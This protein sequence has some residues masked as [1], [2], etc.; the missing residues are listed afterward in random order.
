M[1]WCVDS[2]YKN[3]RLPDDLDTFMY[4][5]NYSTSHK[6]LLLPNKLRRLFIKDYDNK[7]L[8]PDSLEILA[9]G[10]EYQHFNI[11]C[12]SIEL[13]SNLFVLL[14]ILPIKLP[15]NLKKLYLSCYVDIVDKNQE[16]FK[17]YMDDNPE[18]EILYDEFIEVKL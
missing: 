2:Y 1:G 3:Y 17:I 12:N 5:S 18:L 8:L 4:L 13:K 7:L 16:I 15:K 9:I 11:F 6:E 10:Y 14:P